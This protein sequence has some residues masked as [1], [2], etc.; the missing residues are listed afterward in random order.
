MLCSDVLSM[1]SKRRVEVIRIVVKESESDKRWWL[2]KNKVGS[3]FEKSK[4]TVIKL[5]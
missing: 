4:M 5:H 3:R 1:G 2:Q